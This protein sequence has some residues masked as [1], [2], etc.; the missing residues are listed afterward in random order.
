MLYRFRF[1]IYGFLIFIF[2]MMFALLFVSLSSKSEPI[3]YDS[4]KK[5]LNRIFTQFE[6]K[7]YAMVP[8][9]G[10]YEVKG[11]N[12]ATFKIIS[13]SFSDAHIGYDD[14]HVYAG[15]II[16]EDLDPSRLTVLGNNYYTDG[17]T[18]Y[19]CAR[20]SEK[21]ESLSAVGFVIRLGGQSLG[22]S[23]KPQNYW[24]PFKKLDES[25]TYLSKPGFAIAA[26]EK[27]AFFKGLE[28]KNSNPKTI[29]PVKIHYYDGDVRDSEGYFTDGRNVYF[30]DGQLPLKYNEKIHEIGIES[31]IPSRSAYLI[32]PQNGM[33]YVNGKPF[34]E[35][36]APYRLLGMNLKHAYQAL[37]VS[38][39]GL[40]FY[41][42]EAEKVIRAGDNPFENNQFQEIAPDVF[43]SGNKVYFLKATE[44]WGR[45][46][47]LLSRTTHLIELEDVLASGIKKISRAD[48]YNGSVWQ[49]GSRYFYFD[50][51]GSSQMM[52]STVYEIKDINTV[53]LLAGDGTLGSEAIRDL[54]K[55]NMSTG[56]EGTT[57]VKAVTDSDNNWYDSY[58]VIFG[59]AGLVYA[60][61]YFFRNVKFH[62]FFIKDGY[63]IMNN[64]SFKKFEISDINKIIFSS[65][66]A[67]SR[68]GGYSGKMQ[69]LQKN[70]NTSRSFIFSSKITLVSQSENEILSYIRELQKE[71]GI[72]GIESEVRH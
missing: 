36:K 14:Q 53:K 18:T 32:N 46:R 71:L 19:Y 3:D 15:N 47:G 50:D 58:W 64:L 37:F 62:P 12:T 44:E 63:L 52:P 9:N 59:V 7:I 57:V 69:V 31:D 25:S 60:I 29:R 21:N 72:D 22:L 39:D 35:S 45:K 27:V 48:S 30:Q 40:Y 16:L 51:A 38:K 10:Y 67:G 56:G 41:D 54:S 13:E 8:G 28:M 2:L 61:S 34:D 20:N 4:N 17:K 24:Y 70:G 6:G 49:H 33:V 43:T 65:F 66:K 68:S 23:D 42:T 5:D 26:G 11:A 55:R 1:L